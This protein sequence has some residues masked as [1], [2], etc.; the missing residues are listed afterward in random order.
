MRLELRHRNG[1]VTSV[2]YNASVYR[3]EAGKTVGVFAAARDVAKAQAA[4]AAVQ[5]E[6]QRFLDVLETLPVIVTL[7]RPDHRVEWVNR[8]VSRGTGR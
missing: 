8:A 6:R 1:H 5:A 2:L 7:F 4:E 3:D